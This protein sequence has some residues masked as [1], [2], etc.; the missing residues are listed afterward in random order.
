MAGYAL[1]KDPVSTV[2]DPIEI[3][4]ILLECGEQRCLIFSFDVLTVGTELQEEILSRLLKLGFLPD[5]I[6]LF[7]SHTHNA[8][9]TDRACAP[10]GEPDSKFVN[11]VADTA[12]SLARQIQRQQ[13][14]E[15]RLDVLQGRLAHSVN[16]RRYW[17]FPTIGRMHGFQLTSVA[18]SPNPSGPKDERATVVLLRKANDGQ[19]LG[20]LW[21]YTCHPTAVVP[22]NVISSDFPGAVRL[23]LRE[24]FGEIPCLFV[25]GFCGNIR[26]DIKASPQKTSLRDRFHKLIRVVAFGNLFPTLSAEDWKR[27]STS[28][29]AAVCSIA[30]SVPAKVFSPASLCTGSA[31]IPL[32]D[33]FTGSTPDRML[34]AKVVR[35]G[36]ELEIVALSAE[37]SVEWQ[38]H[39]DQV[40]PPPS[41]RIRL[42]AGYLG[43]L[44]GYLPTAAQIPEGGYEVEGFQPFFGLSGHFDPNKLEPAVTGCIKTAFEMLECA[45]RYDSIGSNR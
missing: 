38:K 3:S 19:T 39:F 8:P 27:W 44:F 32:G 26:P 6:V 28:V 37:P 16:R 20:A 30:R 1:R 29:A 35:I 4:A 43:A 5:E 9:A 21:H 2:L 18:F 36:D 33:F 34:A 42:Y 15:V 12:E 41:G 22:S 7:A 10:L 40:V 13:P 14:S 17:P 31:Q 45:E 24:Q 23:A 11:D 25:Q